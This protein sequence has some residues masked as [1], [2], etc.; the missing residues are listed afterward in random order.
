M[1]AEL[2]KKMVLSCHEVHNPGLSA[3]SSAVVAYSGG[4]LHP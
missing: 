4:M 3:A 2:L 1:P